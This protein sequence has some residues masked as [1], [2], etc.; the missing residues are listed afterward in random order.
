MKVTVLMIAMAAGF[1]M[2]HES[3]VAERAAWQAVQVSQFLG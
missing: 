1:A 2:Q 3:C